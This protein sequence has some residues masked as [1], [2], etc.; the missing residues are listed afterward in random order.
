VLRQSSSVNSKRQRA[1]VVVGRWVLIDS[2]LCHA[3]IRAGRL[4]SPQSCKANGIATSFGCTFELSSMYAQRK[5][6]CN[7]SH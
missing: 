6:E 7:K 5:A 2:N 4:Q 1:F 3:D